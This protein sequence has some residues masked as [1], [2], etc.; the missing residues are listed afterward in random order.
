MELSHQLVDVT[1]A[2]PERPLS[3]DE[4][5]VLT[6]RIKNATHEVCLLLL[7]AHQR[8]A[9]VPLGYRSWRE[10]VRSEL[11]LS[12]SRSYEL[13]D[14]ARVV[15][16]IQKEA[17]TSQIPDISPYAAGQIRPHLSE[18]TRMIRDRSANLP[19]E[20]V[21]E[22]V[23]EVIREVRTRVVV[24]QAEARPAE[25]PAL[26]APVPAKPSESPYGHTRRPVDPER[27]SAAIESLANMPPAQEVAARIP[28]EE[29]HRLAHLKNA[30]RRLGELASRWSRLRR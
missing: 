5:H 18:V 11:G 16:V 27:L 22:V 3:I 21:T 26:P 13:L 23:A 20:H 15:R 6:Q 8:R 24:R 19:E 12:R 30:R 25:P 29:A 9:W 28:E 4:A 10:Y 17:R 1:A 14:Q 2:A 7:E